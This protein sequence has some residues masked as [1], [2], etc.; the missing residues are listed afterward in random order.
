M[1]WSQSLAQELPHAMGVAMIIIIIM[2]TKYLCVR[3]YDRNF[4]YVSH[5]SFIDIILGRYYN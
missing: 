3:E 1:A 5:L 2:F 4:V